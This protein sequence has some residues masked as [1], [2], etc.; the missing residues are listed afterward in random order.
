M[1]LPRAG[2]FLAARTGSVCR[3]C[4][5]VRAA[6]T[7]TAISSVEDLQRLKVAELKEELLQRGLPSSGR[8]DIL[9]AR[10]AA[11]MKSGGA[12]HVAAAKA[13]KAPSKKSRAGSRND[14]TVVKSLTGPA[15]II[16]ESPAKYAHCNP[17]S[18]ICSYARLTRLDSTRLD[19]TRFDS[20]RL[21]STRLDSTRLDSTPMLAEPPPPSHQRSRMHTC[22]SR[23]ATISKFVGDT[24][25]VLASNGHVRSLPSKANSVSIGTSRPWL[26]RG[27][28]Y[29]QAV[30]LDLT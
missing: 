18:Q 30:A 19:S 1:L 10:L 14:A 13:K 3:T 22:T 28:L 4:P 23:C 17:A 8:K 9:I 7:Y 27:S 26:G 15:V 21:V 24:F 6:M 25:V 11:E 12:G 20:T 29:M 5:Q 2:G 16:V